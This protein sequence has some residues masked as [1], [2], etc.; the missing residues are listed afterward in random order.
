M[1]MNTYQ[2]QDA[3][4]LQVTTTLCCTFALSGRQKA[5]GGFFIV[6]SLFWRLDSAVEHC[7]RC[8]PMLSRMPSCRRPCVVWPL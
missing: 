7:L 6:W 4:A 8:C 1:L 5:C 2:Q 3:L